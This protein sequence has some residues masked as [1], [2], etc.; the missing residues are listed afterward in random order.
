MNQ[1]ILL[2]DDD[3][4]MLR[5]LSMRLSAAGYEVTEAENAEQARARLQ[6]EPPRLVI[7]DVRLPDGDGLALFDEIHAQHPVLPVILLTA[8]GTIPDAVAATSRGVFDYLTKPFDS[9]TLLDKVA[10]AFTV[11]PSAED[12]GAAWSEQIVSRSAKM[13]ELLAEARV[14]AGGETP[15]VIEGESG[16]G[17]ELLAATMHAASP[18][19]SG[20]FVVVN[21]GA[22][23]EQ[24]LESELFGTVGADNA[25]HEGLLQQAAGGTLLLDEVD[26]MPLPV[27]AKLARVLEEKE[28]RLLGAP[29]GIPVDVRILSTSRQSLEAARGAGRFRDDL[30][31]KLAVVRLRM[32][33]LN[34]RREDIPLLARH[35]LSALATAQGKDVKGYAPEALEA[36]VTAEW[37]GNVRQLYHVVEQVCALTTTPLIPFS[38]VERALHTPSMQSLTYAQAKQRFERD[39]L[40]QLLK[41][42]DGN[43]SDAAKLADRNR[44]KFYSLLQR[45]GLT[46]SLF[47]NTEGKKA[48]G[49]AAKAAQ[50]QQREAQADDDDDSDD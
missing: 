34:E 3:A 33:S 5:L 13:A 2:V 43:V 30:F 41:L 42:T 6:I 29:Q 20:P 12:E 40:V 19:G 28:I 35:F 50:A 44:T 11:V 16:T 49:R 47:R 22:I 10:R 24:L 23:P 14:V 25:G 36:L 21:C 48:G 9:Q 46:P 4:S 45:H 39:Y 37:P 26:E 38:L 17:K 15:T 18:R 32:P 27:Q 1:R 31:Y 8:H 7:S